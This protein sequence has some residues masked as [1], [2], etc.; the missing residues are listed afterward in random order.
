MLSVRWLRAV[1]VVLSLFSAALHAEG[2]H[3]KSAE[4]S[5]TEAGYML[6]ADYEVVLSHTLEEARARHEQGHGCPND[7][8]AQGVRGLVQGGSRCGV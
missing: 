3:I 8:T 1:V 6:D 5:Q 7:R 2:I 4:L